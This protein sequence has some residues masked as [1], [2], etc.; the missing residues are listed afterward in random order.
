MAPA[1]TEAKLSL[2]ESLVTTEDLATT[3]RRA[4]EWVA[5]HGLVKQALCAQ[6][7]INARLEDAAEGIA[8]FLEKR[9][10]EFKGR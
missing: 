8:A 2:L 5:D 4:V 1:S 10:P 9:P 6:L 7:S 3:A